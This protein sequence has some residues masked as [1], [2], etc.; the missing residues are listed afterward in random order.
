MQYVTTTFHNDALSSRRNI[1]HY[2]KIAWTRSYDPSIAF[3]VVGTSVV[4][5]VDIIKG[6]S[7]QFITESDKFYYF[8]ESDYAIQIEYERFIEEPLGGLSMAM[9][10]VVL[11]NTSKRFTFGYDNII[12]QFII[13]QRVVRLGVGFGTKSLPVF[14]GV[15]KDVKENRARRELYLHCRDYVDTFMGY[16]MDSSMFVNKRTDEIIEAILIAVGFNPEQYELDEG[17]NTVGFAWFDKG[18]KAADAIKELCEAE[19]G[20]FYQDE[21]GILRFENREHYTWDPHL[22]AQIT[23]TTDDIIDMEYDYSNVINKCIVYAKPR[24]VQPIQVVWSQDS[25]IEIPAN[26]QITVWAEYKYLATGENN[27]C[28]SAETP[29]EATDFITNT[30]SS[31]SGANMASSVDLIEFTP[32]AESAKMVFRNTHPTYSAYFTKLQVKGTPAIIVNSIKE[33]YEDAASMTLYGEQGI[34]IDNNYIDDPDF[35]HTLSRRIV[36]KY[37]NPLK[38]VV[39]KIK[40]IPHLQLK[41]RIDVTDS[42]IGTTKSYRLMKIRGV[43]NSGEGFIQELTLREITDTESTQSPHRVISAKAHINVA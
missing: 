25:A 37:A 32:F 33:T 34:T 24:E 5:G 6:D 3:A 16:S 36:E 43:M 21:Q 26:S 41:D 42:D 31:G 38:R 29:V 7:S 30:T 15:S 4:G 19:E 23:L 1:N 27:P 14:E 39:V 40:G 28:S 35:A 13:P 10:D 2:A 20:N 9:G 18:T 8:N 12:G 11:D 22:G 17:I